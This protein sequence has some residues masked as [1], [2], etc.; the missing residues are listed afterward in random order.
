MAFTEMGKS[1]ASFSYMVLHFDD[2]QPDS[3]PHLLLK[4]LAEEAERIV[5]R[6]NVNAVAFILF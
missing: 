5:N 6:A 2:M 4:L 3:A 1:A